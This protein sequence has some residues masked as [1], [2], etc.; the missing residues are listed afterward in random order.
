MPIIAQLSASGK[1]LLARIPEGALMALVLVFSCSASFGLGYLA[2]QEGGVGQVY[3]EQLPLEHSLPAASASAVEVAPDPEPAMN[4]GGQYV[5]SK[6]GTRYYL[7]W[8]GGVKNI[9]EENKVWFSTKADAEAAGYTP[10][11]NCKG[12]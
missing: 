10:A 6:N 5:A 2:S 12:I 1:R 8:C 9:K 7:P 11:A 4:A 3:I